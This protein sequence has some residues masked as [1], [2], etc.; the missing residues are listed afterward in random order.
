MIDEEKEDGN[1]K[2]VITLEML[3][4]RGDI[5]R[6]C[7]EASVRKLNLTEESLLQH[8]RKLFDRLKELLEKEKE[9]EEIKAIQ[10]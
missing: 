5:I 8:H 9:L 10:K 4:L 7:D 3:Q 6:L 2:D 1:E